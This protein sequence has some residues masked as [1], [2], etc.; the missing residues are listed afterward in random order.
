VE[1]TPGR[2]ALSIMGAD[3]SSLN[4]S[5]DFGG[6]YTY[7]DGTPGEALQILKDHGLNA[8]RLRVWV[9]PADG[10]RIKPS[11]GRGAGPSAGD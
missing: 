3:V 9:D 4:K 8:I 5:E 2:A 10:Y 1:F 7:E 6:I 11:F